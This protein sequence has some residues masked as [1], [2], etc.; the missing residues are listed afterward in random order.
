VE[1]IGRVIGYD[2]IP[3]MPLPF[4]P[5]TIANE[6]Y[7]KIRAIKFA[8][9][10]QGYNEVMN[11]SFR[12]KGDV[13][14][15]H[16][17]KDKSALRTNLTD[18]LKE[19]YDMNRLNAALLG[20]EEV[21]I[22]EI[23]TIFIKDNEQMNV[24]IADKSGIKEWGVDEY[25]L[26]AGAA[27]GVRIANTAAQPFKPWSPYPFIT[28]DIAVWTDEA[29]KVDLQKI[30]DDF[31][32]A[33]CARPATLFDTFTKDDK[34]SFAYRLVFQSFEKTLTDSEVEPIFQTL[35]ASITAHSGMTIR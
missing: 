27:G 7:E 22:F 1:E 15:A 2:T 35:V 5:T 9:S 18:A 12:K 30:I 3:S 19:S 24:A 14:I 11:Y 6:Q 26:E 10:E 29:G 21:K 20:L 31:A 25:V 16:G 32:A 4:T 33:Y 28:R 23:G 17:P 13:Y 8:L 34:T